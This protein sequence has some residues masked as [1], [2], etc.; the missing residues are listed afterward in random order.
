MKKQSNEATKELV[1]DIFTDEKPLT[2][3]DK[4]PE[5]KEAV[6]SIVMHTCNNI[7]FNAEKIE[8]ALRKAY[9]S[10]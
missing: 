9:N 3:L 7:N 4:Y 1:K 5:F 2:G 10:L 8:T 6:K